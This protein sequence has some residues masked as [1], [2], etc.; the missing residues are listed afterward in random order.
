MATSRLASE[1]LTCP[2]L[3]LILL[4]ISSDNFQNPLGES[5][6]DNLKRSRPALKALILVEFRTRSGSWFQ[7]LITLLLK[8]SCA[9]LNG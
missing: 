8:K 7:Y 5:G 1:K 3:S 9:D 4:K 2:L 6:L